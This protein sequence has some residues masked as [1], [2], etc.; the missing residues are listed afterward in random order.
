MSQLEVDNSNFDSPFLCHLKPKE[1]YLS[2]SLKDLGNADDLV[3]CAILQTFFHPSIL[4]LT[5]RARNEN[6]PHQSTVF[7]DNCSMEY[8]KLLGG[9]LQLLETT[10]RL[11]HR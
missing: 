5:A 4:A 6:L 10:P 8:P 2:N 11:P 1:S 7:S 9:T 3:C